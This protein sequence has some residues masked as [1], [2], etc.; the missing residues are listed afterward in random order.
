MKKY[1]ILFIFILSGI[2][3]SQN[4]EYTGGEKLDDLFNLIKQHYVDTTNDTQLIE[5]AL[6]GVLKELDPHSYYLDA[7]ELKASNE[8]LQGNFEGV[9]IQFNLFHDTILVV[10]P[11]S[12]GPSEK[13]GI[14]SGDKIIKVNDTIVAG[15]KITNQDVFSKLRGKKGTKVRL[16]VLRRG[17]KDLIEFEVTRDKI[18]VFSVD[19]SYMAAPEVG[20]IKINRFSNT[21][22]SEFLDGWAKLKSKGA[23]HLILDLSDNSGGYLHAAVSLADEFLK[24]GEM[25]VYTEGVKSPKKEYKATYSG[26]LEQGRLVVMID[27][28]SASASEIVSGAIQDHDRGVLVGR[29]SYGKGLVQN[30]YNFDDGSAVRLTTSRYYIPSGRCIQKPYEGGVDKYYE[31]LKNRYK[32]GELQDG[33]KFQYPDSLKFYTDNKRLVFGGGGVMPDFFIPLDTTMVTPLLININRKNCINEFCLDYVDKNRDELKSKYPNFESFE[34][35]FDVAKI[36]YPSFWKFVTSKEIKVNKKDLKKSNKF[37]LMRLKASMAQ[38]LFGREEFFR[39][40]NTE[41]NVYLKALEVIQRPNYKGVDFF[42]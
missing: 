23:K 15:V 5:N 3:F 31:D 16:K 35:N 18:P 19:A 27:E 34:K 4:T 12:G 38:D 2:T 26:Q 25:I 6:K 11:I 8:P 30:T 13:V 22:M 7:K 1:I 41:N 24:N 33:D 9:G 28:G 40:W 17:N 21:T 36:L 37:I 20:Y 10:S 29:R 32:N 14:R 39:I 42:E